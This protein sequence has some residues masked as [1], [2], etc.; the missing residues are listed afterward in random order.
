MKRSDL[1]LRPGGHPGHPLPVTHARG[2]DLWGNRNRVASL[3]TGA[4]DD[5]PEAAA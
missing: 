4:G 3:A 2:A 1:R 5:E